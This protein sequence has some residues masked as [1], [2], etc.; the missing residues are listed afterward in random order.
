[1]TGKSDLFLSAVFQKA[2][3]EVIFL[4]VLHSLI[5]ANADLNP[6]PVSKEKADPFGSEYTGVIIT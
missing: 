1:M 4:E 5:H 2:F 6:D 3:I